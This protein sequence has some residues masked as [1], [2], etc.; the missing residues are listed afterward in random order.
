[1]LHT[2]ENAN[3]RLTFDSDAGALVSLV[4]KVTGDE[5]VKIKERAPVC[6]LI[7]LEQGQSEKMNY[8]PSGVAQVSSSDSG[9]SVRYPGV[10]DSTR[11]VPIGV[12]ICIRLEPE[13]G[14]CVWTLRVENSTLDISV[15]ETLFPYING[16]YLGD[17]WQDDE[18]IYPHHAGEKIIA[19]ART[20]ASDRYLNF[21]RAQT[22]AENG[23]WWREINYCGLAS[24]MWMEYYDTANGLYIAS[25]DDDFL[26]TGIRVETGGPAN[27]WMGFCFRKYHRILPGTT[28]EPKPYVIAAHTSDWHWGATRY[29][30]WIR[31]Y[32][33]PLP[34]PEFLK[35]EASLT[36]VYNLKR[37]GK[38]ENRYDQLPAI[39]ENG[40]QAF[41]SRHLFVAS[42]NRGGF[43]WNYP[44]YQPDMELGSPW[45]LFEACQSVNRQGGFITFYINTRIFDVDCDFYGSLGKP[46]AVKN[47]RGEPKRET[48]GGP[49]TFTVTCPAHRDWQKH[50]S[51]TAA[52]MVRAY[53]A[54]GI[55]LDQLGSAEPIPCYD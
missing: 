42:W 30:Q 3:A 47:E 22:H 18:L 7:C 34:N 51:D 39:F 17:D 19:P 37:V 1:M 5:Y 21:G 46:W 10:T 32:I 23:M 40:R 11:V 50:L 55:Y 31:Q 29:R 28:W 35:S 2:L 20:L 44:E 36:K 48:Y 13:N 8:T 26:V 53:G 9:L 52:W 4:N 14:E 38:V 41:Q 12:T 43:D 24:M 27:P 16:I 6:R 45:E 15:V 54:K 33:Q 25:H 49:R